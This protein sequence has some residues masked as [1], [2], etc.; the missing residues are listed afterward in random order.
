MPRLQQRNSLIENPFLS[1]LLIILFSNHSKIESK[2][3]ICYANQKK[4]LDLLLLES[5]QNKIYMKIRVLLISILSILLIGSCVVN[6]EQFGTYDDSK[7]KTIT[8]KEGRELYLFWNQL[9]IKKLDK[10]IKHKN[11]EKIT[12]RKPFDAVVFYGT[13]GIFSFYSVKIKIP[14]PKDPNVSGR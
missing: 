10:R 8:Y 7:Y 4:S 5:T 9:P 13:I 12:K 14:D 2:F 11:Y 1:P 6:K 3:T